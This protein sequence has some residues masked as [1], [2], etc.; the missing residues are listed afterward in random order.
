MQFNRKTKYCL[1]CVGILL[2]CAHAIMGPTPSFAIG[3]GDIKKDE[4]GEGKS[5]GPWERKP[6]G[7]EKY[8]ESG[9]GF[10]S[11]DPDVPTIGSGGSV[12]GQPPRGITRREPPIGER[13]LL[14][15]PPLENVKISDKREKDF[16]S[17][18]VRTS[19]YRK[20]SDGRY[21]LINREDSAFSQ[22]QSIGDEAPGDWTKM[23]FDDYIDARPGLKDYDRLSISEEAYIA[24]RDA[25]CHEISNP[26][27]RRQCLEFRKNRR[28][29]WLDGLTQKN[30]DGIAITED[31][32]PL[33][34]KTYDV[35]AAPLEPAI[36]VGKKRPELAYNPCNL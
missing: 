24:L 27:A 28:T 33:T 6:S 16:G 19:L 31:N 4:K 13:P 29:E 17:Y 5:R 7:G 22:Q 9:G 25:E 35:A 36:K 8:P 21:V 2:F 18:I 20:D 34:G 26:T 30:D 11:I 15:V 3:A 10:I 14:V 32:V 12:T 23:T 1:L